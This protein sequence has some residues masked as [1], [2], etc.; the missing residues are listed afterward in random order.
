[1]SISTKTILFGE[2]QWKKWSVWVFSADEISQYFPLDSM[3]IY[4]SLS[5]A[6]EQHNS[7][8]LS[9]HLLLDDADLETAALLHDWV[10]L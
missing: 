6:E 9:G 3:F 8:C 2:R 4:Y 10:E 7:M 5:H 1:M